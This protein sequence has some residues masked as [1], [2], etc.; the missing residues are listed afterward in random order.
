M[1]RQKSSFLRVHARVWAPH[2]GI[3]LPHRADGVFQRTRVDVAAAGGKGAIAQTLRKDLKHGV[4]IFGQSR[5]VDGEAVTEPKP[6]F[7]RGIGRGAALG[8][9]N[10]LN[11]D[12]ISAE[13][14]A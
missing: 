7:P 3:R 4:G 12:P 6:E 1:V 9:R 14:V 13:L 8:T 11:S 5:G 2:A 10:S